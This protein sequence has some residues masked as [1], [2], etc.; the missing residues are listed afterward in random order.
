MLKTIQGNQA[1]EKKKKTTQINRQ[2]PLSQKTRATRKESHPMLASN[3]RGSK[4]V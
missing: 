3:P 2:I 1:M 4:P